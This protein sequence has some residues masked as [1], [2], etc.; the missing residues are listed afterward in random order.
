M[1]LT[2]AHLHSSFSSDSSASMEEMITQGIA[3]GMK[4]LCFTD[5]YDP[6]YPDNPEGLDFLL[7]FDTSY[8]TF[9]RLKEKYSD[10]I[11]LLFGIEVGVQPQVSDTLEH[12]Y[13]SYGNRYDF[14][15][16][17]CHIVEG[18][19]PYDGIYFQKY[20][21]VE[22]LR[23]YFSAVF[24]NLRRFPHFQSAGHLDYVSRY[25]PKPGPAFC[26]QDYADILDPLL[27]YLIDHGKALEI[28]SAGLRAG[29]DHPNPHMD[30]L[31]RYRV[32]GGEL[33]TIGSDAH[34]PEHIAQKFEVLQDMLKEAGFD[35]YALYRNKKPE[36]LKI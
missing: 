8:Q 28:N 4:T 15:I 3:L 11:D 24:D 2:D 1:I 27:F 21:P 25:L 22:G 19:D 9:L 36:F 13:A 35:Y 30:I 34:C 23:K 31:H 18:L 17:S 20:T 33:I 7:D 6:D 26:Y 10:Q 29:L 5:H 12:F 14:I 16:N 32:L